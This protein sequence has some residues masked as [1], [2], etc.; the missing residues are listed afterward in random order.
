MDKLSKGLRRLADC[1]D[2]GEVPDE[3]QQNI[4]RSLLSRILVRTRERYEEHGRPQEAKLI[5]R[6]N[7]LLE[8]M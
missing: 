5:E 7:L 2:A 4:C 6:L 8:I 1:V 3:G